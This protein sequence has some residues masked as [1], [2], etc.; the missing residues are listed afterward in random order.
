MRANPSMLV[1]GVIVMAMVSVASIAAE[2]VSLE[3]V[4][5]MAYHPVIRNTTDQMEVR[6]IRL[7][8]GVYEKGR[9]L[10][11]QDYEFL[12]AG[13]IALGDLNGDGKRDAAIV[14]YHMKGDRKMTLVAVVLDVNGKP[15]H[16]VSREFGDGTE[17]MDLKCASSI[18]PDKR[19]GLMV[20]RGCVNVEVSNETC[21]NGQGRTMTY[22][23]DGKRLLGAEPFI[24]P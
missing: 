11:D 21:C 20:K 2:P 8:N 16:A 4:K 24:R 15:F 10:V 5:N 17:I 7:R 22:M 23:F 13:Q 12:R 14:L 9:R 19:T 6:S 1:I 18:V 3:S